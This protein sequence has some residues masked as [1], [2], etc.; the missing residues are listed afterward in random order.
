MQWK[1]SL[2][3]TWIKKNLKGDI[4]EWKEEKMA[5]EKCLYKIHNRVG[6]SRERKLGLWASSR[7]I[8]DILLSQGCFLLFIVNFFAKEQ[9][10]WTRAYW[11]SKL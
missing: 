9:L 7:H 10:T 8:L 5:D 3:L 1:S 2:G 6:K 4:R 11:A